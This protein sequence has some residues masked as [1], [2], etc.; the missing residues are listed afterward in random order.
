MDFGEPL[1]QDPQGFA[2]R[3][4]VLQRMGREARQFCPLPAREDA[5]EQK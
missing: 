4:Q 5:P 3:A 2:S 1:F